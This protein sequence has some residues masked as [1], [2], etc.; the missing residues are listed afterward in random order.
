MELGEAEHVK[1][2]ILKSVLWFALKELR[3]VIDGRRI[4]FISDEDL[5]KLQAY[6]L[7]VLAVGKG[8][9]VFEAGFFCFRVLLE[10]GGQSERAVAGI[11]RQLSVRIVLVDLPVG[12]K[13]LIEPVR[14]KICLGDAHEEIFGEVR[15]L[16]QKGALI[17]Q[18]LNTAIDIHHKLKLAG[19][20]DLISLTHEIGFQ[21][22]IGFE[23]ARR[24]K[25]KIIKEQGEEILLRGEHLV[26]SVEESHVKIDAKPG[27]RRL[28]QHVGKKL[29]HFAPLVGFDVGLREPHHG[30][31][32]LSLG[33]ALLKHDEQHRHGLAPFLVA[34]VARGELLPDRK[35]FK[36]RHLEFEKLLILFS[37]LRITL[38]LRK[39]VSIELQDSAISDCS[40]DEISGNSERRSQ[41]P[42]NCH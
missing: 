3:I 12:P 18:V 16:L 11:F 10:L 33:S 23:Q 41:R 8:R 21:F 38:G 39:G 25:H 37:G 42:P 40:W 22:L 6:V 30:L 34:H 28:G 24:R 13:R 36:I 15:R 9:H 14:T 35:A 32:A 26:A 29:D 4:L 20:D 31:F 17:L 5:A 2:L 19:F 27:L 1:N 7:P